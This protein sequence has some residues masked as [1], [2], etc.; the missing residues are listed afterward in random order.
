MAEQLTIAQV[1]KLTGLASHTLRYYERQFPLLLDVERTKGGHRIYRR[2][3]IDAINSIVKL[4]KE[5][6]TSIKQA[7]QLLSPAEQENNLSTC[8]AVET[9]N[10]QTNVSNLLLQVIE[11]LDNICQINQKRDM[12]MQHLLS[13]SKGSGKED[14]LVQIKQCRKETRETMRLYQT[15][16]HKRKN[17]N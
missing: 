17:A 8:E 3:H 1:S 12:M 7:Q 11:R 14:L 5:Q 16:L 4:L 6:R 10:D 2:H 13:N 15:L 9:T